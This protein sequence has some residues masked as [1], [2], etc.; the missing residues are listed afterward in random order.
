MKIKHRLLL[1]HGLLIG[2]ALI[3][4]LINA[5]AY[6]GMRD[7]S[8]TVNN[9]GRL[10]ALSYN[11]GRIAGQIYI[12]NNIDKKQ[13]MQEKLSLNKNEFRS[14]LTALL[15]GEISN[16][17]VV[18]KLQDIEVEWD[19]VFG[20][21]YKKIIDHGTAYV[22][23]NWLNQRIESFV[24]EID[25]MAVDYSTYSDEKV[26][27]ALK[28]NAMLIIILSIVAIYSLSTM[29]YRIRKPIDMLMS[30]MKEFSATEDGLTEKIYD[31]KVDEISEMGQYFNI[32]MFDQLTK[33]YNRRAGLAKLNNMVCVESKKH[34]K[35]SLCFIDINGLKEVN[36]ILGH[37]KGDELIVSTAECIKKTVRDNDFVIRMGG[38]EFLI[39]LNGI[40]AK[41]AEKVWDRIKYCYEEINKTGNRPYIINVSHGIAQYDSNAK[42]IEGQDIEQLIKLADE[43]M[44]EEKRYLKEVLK[45]PVVR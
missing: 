23:Y 29:H 6:T 20:P 1:T 24:E 27:E 14:N 2:L 40:G 7:N 28:I 44:Y 8:E 3:I 35:T 18:E 22:D 45:K 38:D 12:E 32:M 15:E 9:L 36:D 30:E 4:V 13:A 19:G 43:R 42:H 34:C 31:I 41:D 37:E 11:M 39:V 16:A 25:Q 17:M 33:V 10:R 5:I 21:T 26:Y